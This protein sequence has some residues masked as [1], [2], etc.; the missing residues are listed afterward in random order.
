VLRHPQGPGG[1]PTS[2]YTPRD[3]AASVLYT[4][5]REQIETFRVEAAHLRDASLRHRPDHLIVGEVGGGEAFDLLQAL[6]TGHGASLCTIHA[7]SATH[8]MTRLASC[9][10]Q[11]GVALGYDA[12]RTLVEESFALVLHLE[13]HLGTRRVVQIHQP[14]ELGKDGGP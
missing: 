11:S 5:V 9:V 8:A 12:I 7:N 6:N 2:T 4:A 1:V 14:S 13:R 10:A 3:P